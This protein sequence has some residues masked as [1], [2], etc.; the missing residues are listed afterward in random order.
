MAIEIPPFCADWSM[1]AGRSDEDARRY[2]ADELRRVDREGGPLL[3]PI[4]AS[5][6]DWLMSTAVSLIREGDPKTGESVV[7]PRPWALR[8]VDGAIPPSSDPQGRALAAA[9]KGKVLVAK[10]GNLG[11]NLSPARPAKEALAFGAD[12]RRAAESSGRNLYRVVRITRTGTTLSLDDA[13]T[14]MRQWGY[15]CTQQQYQYRPAKTADAKRHER[16]LELAHAMAVKTGKRGE[17]IPKPFGQCNWLV[18]EVCPQREGAASA[19]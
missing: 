11:G 12:A 13:L 9:D 1:Y 18:E 5:L 17:E 19:A 8:L 4:L 7:E 6:D 15:G 16:E 2:I 3:R 14:V 10:V